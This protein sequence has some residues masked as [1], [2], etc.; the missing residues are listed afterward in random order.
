MNCGAHP[1]K[2]DKALFRKI[3]FP[4]SYPSGEIPPA[5][6]RFQKMRGPLSDPSAD[7]DPPHRG[8]AGP[9]LRMLFR[10]SRDPA[11]LPERMV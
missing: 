6:G 4:G 5:R 2:G 1:E 11:R 8:M 9:F 3:V 7:R 10:C